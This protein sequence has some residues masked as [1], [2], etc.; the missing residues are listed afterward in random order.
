MRWKSPHLE[1]EYSEVHPLVRKALG[2]LELKLSDWGFPEMTVTQ[3]F[4][5]PEEQEELY[6]RSL[7]K[8]HGTEALARIAARAKFSWH[9]C[10]TAVDFRNSSYTRAQRKKIHAWLIERCP[11]PAWE[12]LD[13]SVGFGQHFHV[14]LRDFSRRRKGTT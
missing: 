1:A 8:E 9:L 12:A 10:R 7:L 5:T 11:P 14:A 13:H 6:W 4:R 2:E 3:V